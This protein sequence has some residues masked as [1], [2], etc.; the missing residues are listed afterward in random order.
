MV[1]HGG[2]SATLAHH[3]KVHFIVVGDITNAVN[4]AGGPGQ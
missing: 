4:K 3:A 2:Q 1:L